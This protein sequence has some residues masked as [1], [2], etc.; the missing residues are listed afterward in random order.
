[1][2]NRS[3]LLFSKNEEKKE[4]GIIFIAHMGG[5]KINATKI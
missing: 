5:E 2:C 3:T 1:M 4:N